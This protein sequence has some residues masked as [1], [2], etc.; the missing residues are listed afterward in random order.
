MERRASEL[1]GGPK[2]LKRT[3]RWVSLSEVLPACA[4]LRCPPAL[5]TLLQ[6]S[7]PKRCPTATQLPQR[8]NTLVNILRLLPA[9]PPCLGATPPLDP[10][11]RATIA[12]DPCTTLLPVA[13]PTV[14]THTVIIPLTTL[15]TTGT[16]KL[17]T[18]TACLLTLPCPCKPPSFNKAGAISEVAVKR[19]PPSFR[20]VKPSQLIEIL[21][22]LS[23]VPLK[24]ESLLSPNQNQSLSL[25]S[26]RSIERFGLSMLFVPSLSTFRSSTCCV[27]VL[28][29]ISHIFL[30]Y[31]FFSASY[32]YSLLSVN[33][34]REGS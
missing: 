19:F 18:V 34:S 5:Q 4:E 27:I 11:I 7:K 33:S 10:A 21:N 31:F 6:L 16:I 23:P 14:G 1:A 2:S 25:A 12:Q 13:V 22:L 3:F 28:A 29:L 17:L 20:A 15:G 26:P 32:C 9:L 24:P 30:G 8:P